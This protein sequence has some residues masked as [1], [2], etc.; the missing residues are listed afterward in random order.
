M[1]RIAII[2][3]EKIRDKTCVGCIKCFKAIKNKDGEFARYTDDIEVIAMCVCSDCPGLAMPK[4]SLVS[5]CCKQYGVDFDIVHIGTCI[6]KAGQ[7]AA[8]PIDPQKLKTM[9]E[10]KMNKQVVIG[11]HTY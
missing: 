3:C 11:T 5:D 8:C 9:I 2:S 6:V 7:T 1:S 4:L 10:E